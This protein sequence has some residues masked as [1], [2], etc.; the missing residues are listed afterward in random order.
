MEQQG[1][2]SHDVYPNGFI[3]HFNIAST[4]MF[5]M[6]G[7]H[8]GSSSYHQVSRQITESF[9]PWNSAF[10]SKRSSTLRSNFRRYDSQNQLEKY[11]MPRILLQGKALPFLRQSS[12]Y[13]WQ[14]GPISCFGASCPY[15]ALSYVPWTGRH[16]LE[17]SQ[18]TI[19]PRILV[20]NS[21]K[22][23]VLLKKPQRI[24]VEERTSFAGLSTNTD[25]TNKKSISNELLGNQC[26]P[27][28][29][30]QA[31]PQLPASRYTAIVGSS[32]AKAKW[33]W[34]RKRRNNLSAKISRDARRLREAR[35]QRKVAYLENETVR[36]CSEL[37]AAKEQKCRFKS[38]P[39][40]N[41]NYF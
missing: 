41:C 34:E 37:N 6:R 38:I 21:G 29:A 39:C 5:P 17:R 36:L 19:A 2:P 16:D 10:F 9:P 13:D 25:P 12:V 24:S 32:A 28:P 3:Q 15:P 11:G 20:A 18:F 40:T 1:T 14:F 8:E 22:T 30:Q 31:L 35:L 4:S 27:K 26:E 7:F 23:E 33:Y